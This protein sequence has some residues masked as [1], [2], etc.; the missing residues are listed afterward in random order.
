MTQPQ[1]Q[2]TFV[3]LKPD[4][5]QRSLI[6]E[7]IKR[8]ERTGLKLVGLKLTV[9]DEKR[10]LEHYSKDDAW[11]LKKGLGIVEGMKSRGEDVT[12]EPIEYGKDIVRALVKFMMVGPVV[13]MVW[14]GNEAMAVVKKIAGTTEPSTSDV[15]TLRGDFTID[16]Y[17]LANKDNRAARNLIHITDPA[18][19]VEE[20]NR[21]ISIWF[22]ES[23]LLS[24]RL[25]VDEMLYDVDLNSTLE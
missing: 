19:G 1:K 18:D 8:I 9:C 21:E 4:A 7:M 17:N 10:L 5:V 24:Y 20:A 23:E 13:Q 12:R 14:E 3:M 16:S 11:Y 2:R 25:L 6:G 22:Q 15:G